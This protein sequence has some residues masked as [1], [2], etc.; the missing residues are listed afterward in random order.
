MILYLI[1]TLV[2]KFYTTS[3]N[4]NMQFSYHTIVHHIF[5]INSSH[6]IYIVYEYNKT[7]NFLPGQILSYKSDE[8]S[9][10]H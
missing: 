6:H 5:F 7:L 8:T 4:F 3:T 2:L 10:K 1:I 9:Y